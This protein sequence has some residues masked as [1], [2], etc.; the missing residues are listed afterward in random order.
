MFSSVSV[1]LHICNITN[2]W[3]IRLILVKLRTTIRDK[4]ELKIGFLAAPGLQWCIWISRASTLSVGR[5]TGWCGPWEIV[6]SL[7]LAYP[8]NGYSYPRNGKTTVFFAVK[9]FLRTLPPG[10]LC[11]KIPK[12]HSRAVAGGTNF[13]Y[14]NSNMLRGKQRSQSLVF[15]TVQLMGSIKIGIMGLEF[16]LSLMGTCLRVQIDAPLLTKIIPIV[17]TLKNIATGAFEIFSSKLCIRNHFQTEGL[18]PKK[19]S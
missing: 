18:S 11:P 4:T 17:K 12:W 6:E 8:R 3:L 10:Q 13:K 7:Y 16:D 19:R 5:T 15:W 1:I 2:K 14:F 9:P